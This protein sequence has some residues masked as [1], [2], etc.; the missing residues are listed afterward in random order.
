MTA[1]ALLLGLLGLGLA[2][3]AAHRLWTAQLDRRLREHEAA[4]EARLGQDLGEALRRAEALELPAGMAA[5][6][7]ADGQ[8]WIRSSRRNHAE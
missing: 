2:A 6:V 3:L 8:T 1:A 4:L 5:E 7:D